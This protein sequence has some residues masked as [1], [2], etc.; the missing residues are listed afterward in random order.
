MIRLLAPTGTAN[1]NLTAEDI[2]RFMD[3][4]NAG[5]LVQV[6]GVTLH[7]VGVAGTEG[8]RHRF[9][10]YMNA[11]HDFDPVMYQTILNKIRELK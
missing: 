2:E 3:K 8:A 10:G 4:R 1:I 7:C 11:L 5:L 6:N 9:I